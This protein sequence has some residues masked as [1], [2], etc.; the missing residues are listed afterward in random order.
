GLLRPFNGRARAV[1]IALLRGHSRTMAATAAG[2]DVDTLRRWEQREPEF[3]RATARAADFGFSSVYEAELYDRA[4]DRSDKAS[5]RLLELLL[6]S[7]SADYREKSQLQLEVVR[8]NEQ[9]GSAL[10][11]G[12]ESA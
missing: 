8:R 3:A 9:A 4:L 1:L 7:R 2:I 6:K 11:E 12:Y 10:L 5:G